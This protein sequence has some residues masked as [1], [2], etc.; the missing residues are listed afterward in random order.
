LV[1][2]FTPKLQKVYSFAVNFDFLDFTSMPMCSFAVNFDL[3]DFASMPMY[4]FTVNFDFL[5]FTFPIS[6]K[7]KRLYRSRYYLAVLRQ[8]L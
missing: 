2:L 3:L 6:T 4:S 1:A 8:P 7:G 5:D